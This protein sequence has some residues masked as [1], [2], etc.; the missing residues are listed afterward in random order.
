MKYSLTVSAWEKTT[1]DVTDALQASMDQYNPIFMM[2][3]SGL[4][5]YFLENPYPNGGVQGNQPRVVGH[6]GLVPV[7]KGVVYVA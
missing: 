1:K 6:H 2:A 5:V 3:D 7:G 4:A